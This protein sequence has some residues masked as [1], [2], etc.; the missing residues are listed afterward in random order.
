MCFKNKVADESVGNKYLK[1]FIFFIF[2]NEINQNQLAEIT[3]EFLKKKKWV[4]FQQ[5]YVSPFETCQMQ[6]R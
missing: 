3:D 4:I 1:C 6:L 2:V 5:L